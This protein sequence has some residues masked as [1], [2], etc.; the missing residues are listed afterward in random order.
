MTFQENPD[1]LQAHLFVITA[2]FLSQS[3][4]KPTAFVDA[5]VNYDCDEPSNF[6][7]L[8]QNIVSGRKKVEKHPSQLSG[9]RRL[10]K[11]TCVHANLSVHLGR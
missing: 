7:N 3:R 9:K 2:R 5:I 1:H 6:D 4:P 11:E 10:M 8:F